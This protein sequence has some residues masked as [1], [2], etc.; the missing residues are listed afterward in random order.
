MNPAAMLTRHMQE[1]RWQRFLAHLS[2]ICALGAALVALWSIMRPGPIS[3]SAFMMVAHVL[4][5]VGVTLYVVTAIIYFKRRRGV[6]RVR[7]P[8]GETVFH[9]GDPAD[10][11][12]TIISGEVEVVRHTPDQG[13]TILNRLGPG[14]YF[15]EMAVLSN[16]PRN[17]SV[18]TLTPVEAMSVRRMDFQTLYMYVP[19]LRQNMEQVISHK[20]EAEMGTTA[21]EASP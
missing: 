1:P 17:A 10:Y 21:P 4:I 19:G 11:I 8:A 15:G 18:R 7:F 13:E 14:Q 5:A 3:L 2:E 9:Q 20:L 6:T 12:Y 16:A